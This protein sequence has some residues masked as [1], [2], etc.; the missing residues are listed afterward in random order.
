MFLQARLE[1][2]G[3]LHADDVPPGDYRL[4]LT[5]S[6]GPIDGRG[7]SRQSASVTTT[8]T[9]PAIPGGSTE[10]PLDL[11]VLKPEVVKDARGRG[12]P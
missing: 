5:Y 12:L 10:E 6:A 2:D 11:G 9:I 1:P 3:T 7:R 4:R 8:F